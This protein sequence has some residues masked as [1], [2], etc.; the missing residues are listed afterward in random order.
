MR[1][2]LH[3]VLSDV[4]PF[5]PAKKSKGDPRGLIFSQ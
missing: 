5:A 2:V 4:L 1:T 3:A